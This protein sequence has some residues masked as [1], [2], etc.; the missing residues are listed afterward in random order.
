MHR[1]SFFP[2]CAR[3]RRA[4][5]LGIVMLFLDQLGSRRRAWESVCLRPASAH[6]G[7]ASAFHLPHR[8][9]ARLPL[10]G[11]RTVWIWSACRDGPARALLSST[12]IVRRMN[13]SRAWLGLGFFTFRRPS[14]PRFAAVAALAWWFAAPSKKRP[15]G[16]AH[17]RLR[18]PHYRTR[19]YGPDRPE[20]HDR[21]ST[22]LIGAH[23]LSPSG[24]RR[25][26]AAAS[27]SRW[28][29]SASAALC[30]PVEIPSAWASSCLH[31]RTNPRRRLSA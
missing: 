12:A 16:K 19:P 25:D 31:H 7:W 8:L 17:P 3:G 24:C 23:S 15:A 2:S 26:A 13:G 6:G 11:R 4:P 28:S 1:T 14:S 9:A 29:P 21:V 10:P 27:S 20:V 22:A 30:L 18:R 5:T